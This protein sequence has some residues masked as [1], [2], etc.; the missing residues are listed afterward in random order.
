MYKGCDKMTKEEAQEV[1]DELNTVRPEKLNESGRRL[2]E[3]IMKIADERDNYKSI[4]NEVREYLIENIEE[5]KD[6][7]PSIDM[8]EEDRYILEMIDRK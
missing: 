6:N 5:W 4:L 7:E 1:L 3:A 2:Y 8:V